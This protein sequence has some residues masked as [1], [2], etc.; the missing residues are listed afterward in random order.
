MFNAHFGSLARSAFSVTNPIRSLKLNLDE[1]I[2]LYS[3][4]E[5]YFR[6]AR[7]PRTIP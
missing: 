4:I 3:S 5:R 2:A 6:L 7:D 1:R